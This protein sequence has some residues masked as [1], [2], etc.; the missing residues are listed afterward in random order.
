[1]AISRCGSRGGNERRAESTELRAGIAL[2]VAAIS[3]QLLRLPYDLLAKRPL[4]CDTTERSAESGEHRASS[5]SGSPLSALCS[6]L[7][8]HAGGDDGRFQDHRAERR[9]R[10]W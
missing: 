3:S 10:L 4:P 2:W 6:P 9:H 1:T 7:P 8:F 5:R